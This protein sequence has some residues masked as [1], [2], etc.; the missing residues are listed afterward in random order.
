MS[1]GSLTTGSIEITGAHLSHC[2]RSDS[3][4]YCASVDFDQPAGRTFIT[5]TDPAVAR[6]VAAAH[7]DAAEALEAEDVTR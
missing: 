3:G 6:A 1:G 7:L 4:H 2:W 5:Y